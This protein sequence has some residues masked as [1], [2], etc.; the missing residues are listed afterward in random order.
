MGIAKIKFIDRCNHPFR[1]GFSMLDQT[2][3]GMI[4]IYIKAAFRNILR[5]KDYSFISI[6]GL[7]IGLASALSIL[8]YVKSELS[9]DAYHLKKDRIYRLATKVANA[10][11][12]G[13][14]KVNG[15]WGPA[16]LENIPE[17][18][19]M[20][21]F[22]PAG[23]NLVSQGDKRF[24]ENDGL[25][26]D[27]AVFEVFSFHLLSGNAEHA[28]RLPNSV[29][30][31]QKMA[32]TYFGDLDPIGKSLEIEN[33]PY[34]VTAIVRDI[35]ENSHFRFSYLLSMGG[36][37]NP[38]RD[39]WEQWNQFYTYLLLK[40]NA[41]P[42]MVADKFKALLPKH[43]EQRIAAGYTPFLQQ[44]TSIHLH[45]NLF[46]EINP[47]SDMLYIYIFSSI[48]FLILI[49]SGINFINL[50]TARAA[51]RGK[52]VGVRK[53]HGAAKRQLVAQYLTESIL[54]SM[55][56][57]AVATVLAS[58]ALPV[59]NALS[60]RH[61]SLDLLRDPTT[62]AS[63]LAI[64]TMVGILSGSYP[65]F[66]MASMKPS[67]VLKGKSA[68]PRSVLR[69]IL[70][71]T[72][73]TLSAFLIIASVVIA[74]QL[75]YIQQKKLGFN[76]SQ[77]IT[78]PIRDDR[79][80]TGYETIRQE[81]LQ[82]PAIADVS[83]SGTL[84]GGGDWGI[85]FEAEGIDPSQ[86]PSMRVLAVDH[87]FIKAFQIE[88]SKG[89][90]FSSDFPSDTVAY[91]IN[92][93]A[94]RQLGWADPIGKRISMQAI[95]RPLAP[96]VG[97]VKDF[98]FRSLHEKIGPVMFFIPSSSWFGVYTIRVQAGNAQDA[99]KFLETKWSV[100]DPGHPFTYNFFDQDYGKLY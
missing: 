11:F 23:Q 2:N 42:T 12:E 9:Y 47:N 45:S 82:N 14:A 28:L 15:P 55:V 92:E 43:L 91:I 71:I 77:M 20:V 22:V 84:P 74:K 62:I 57:L 32:L 86:L 5:H 89:R 41:S 17:V 34:L 13:I 25:Y 16:A 7:A 21:R 8:L 83:V 95:H 29:V 96:V 46:R 52:E 87:H 53:T 39:S 36:L 30:I 69:N 44:L 33:Q 60:G 88:L 38:L 1:R 31:N 99:L 79:M 24:Y 85:P 3:L 61:L 76:P 93:E 6:L 19:Q 80:K 4:A 35:P 50:S 67:E 56:A 58:L 27:P 100:F 75:N 81:L 48:G 70:V 18:E 78:I 37:S 63:F 40:E 66:L 72:Q 73:F 98:H 64:A 94:A 65:A 90:D 49:I 51:A 26:A 10:S 68:S 59:F 54:L 97:V